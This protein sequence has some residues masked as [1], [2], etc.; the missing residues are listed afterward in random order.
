[1]KVKIRLDTLT[2]VKD[3]VNTVSYVGNDVHLTDGTN[4][5]VSAKS[6]MGAIYTM[7]WA[8]VFCES[9]EDIY[10]LISRFIVE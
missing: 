6:L 3:F 10:H 2:D 5:K 1:M 9:K 4:L 8:E 7:E